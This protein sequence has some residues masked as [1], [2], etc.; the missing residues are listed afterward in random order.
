MDRNTEFSVRGEELELKI[1][2]P[3][4]PT[5]S[6]ACDRYVVLD[7]ISIRM[8]A[9]CDYLGLSNDERIKAACIEGVRKYGTNICGAL[10]FSGYTEYHEEFERSMATFLG[11]KACMMLIT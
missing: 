6:S 9:S 2:D 8:F 4:Y 5:V 3:F 10:V 7:N 11:K 1:K